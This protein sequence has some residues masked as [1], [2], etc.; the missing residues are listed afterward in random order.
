[1]Q[2]HDQKEEHKPMQTRDQKYAVDA[3]NKVE[4]VL[5][6]LSQTERDRYGSMAHKLPILIR[7]AGLAQSLEFVNARGKAGH[8]R[9]LNDL[10]LTVIQQDTEALLSRVRN[11]EIRDYIYLTQQM[12]AALLWYKR[13]AQSV[14]DI[15]P[16][17]KGDKE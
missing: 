12:V 15:E 14:L 8:K 1:M 6:V 3:Y 5:G 9:L 10:A 13:F 17:G 16:G 4:K 2:T 11:A 7:T